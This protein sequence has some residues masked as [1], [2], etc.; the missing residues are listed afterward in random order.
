M[1][2]WTIATYSQLIMNRRKEFGVK[3]SQG[4]F[5]DINDVGGRAKAEYPNYV[6][7]RFQGTLQTARREDEPNSIVLADPSELV[8]LDQGGEENLD[9]VG[10][11]TVAGKPKNTNKGKGKATDPETTRVRAQGESAGSSRESHPALSHWKPSATIN[12]D[13]KRADYLS[14][15]FTRTFSKR[16]RS[17]SFSYSHQS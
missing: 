8:V 3:P 13:A 15:F 16:A 9:L 14:R 4:P 12:T 1:L 11:Q 10:D 5:L 6:S 2:A 17:L 7:N